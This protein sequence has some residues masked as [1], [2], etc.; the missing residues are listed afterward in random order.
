[1][2]INKLKVKIGASLLFERFFI[3]SYPMWFQKPTE[4]LYTCVLAHEEILLSNHGLSRMELR[5]GISA[6][7]NCLLS[8]LCVLHEQSFY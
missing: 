4:L 3:L 2:T 8:D 6:R 1:M 7:V 5:M